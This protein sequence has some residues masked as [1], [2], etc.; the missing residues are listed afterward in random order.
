MCVLFCVSPGYPRSGSSS[1]PPLLCSSLE[2]FS[3][4]VRF[5]FHPAQVCVSE[6]E[7]G[8]TALYLQLLGAAVIINECSGHPLASGSFVPAVLRDVPV[9]SL[10]H[11]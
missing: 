11:F 8:C 7:G 3:L 4:N 5:P 2:M 10:A 6:C 9:L 1:D